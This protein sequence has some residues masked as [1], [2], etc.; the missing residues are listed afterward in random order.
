M[1]ASRRNRCTAG[2]S[3]L[4]TLRMIV[5]TIQALSP[6]GRRRFTLEVCCAVGSALREA[7]VRGPADFGATCAPAVVELPEYRWHY[8]TEEAWADTRP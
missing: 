3:V 8:V 2:E 7:E 1:T 6:S 4:G 5:T